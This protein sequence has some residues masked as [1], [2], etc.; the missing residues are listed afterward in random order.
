MQFGDYGKNLG[1][2][3]TGF[4]AILGCTS[5]EGFLEIW[6]SPSQDS[7]RPILM[8]DQARD[9]LLAWQFQFF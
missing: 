2:R 6:F 8:L 4:N 5:F 9:T 1:N 3:I 7:Q